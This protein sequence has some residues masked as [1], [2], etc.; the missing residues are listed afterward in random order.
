M[1]SSLQKECK[2]TVYVL[3]PDEAVRDGIRVLLDSFNIQV[4]AFPNAESFMREAAANTHGCALIESHLS[5]LD[6]LTLLSRL[7]E[8]GNTIP[9]LLLTSSHD[10]HLALQA[11]EKGA[12]SVIHKPL[13]NEHL[14]RQ[15]AR[16]LDPAPPELTDFR[17]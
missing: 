14:L 11:L 4:R 7:R 3:D 8:M 5:D 2:N 15:L 13:L 12:A 17:T 9:V 1:S 16:L 10:E 6:G